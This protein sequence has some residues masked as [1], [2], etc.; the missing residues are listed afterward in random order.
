MAGAQLTIRIGPVLESADHE[1]RKL[2]AF[3]NS[4]RDR[5]RR[6]VSSYP[7][8]QDARTLSLHVNRAVLDVD[9]F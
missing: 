9:D 3:S 7:V 6:A 4:S 8:P 2:S 5:S 1:H